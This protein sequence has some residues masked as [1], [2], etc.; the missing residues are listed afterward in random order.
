VINVSY[1]PNLNLIERV[2]KFVKQ[3]VLYSRYYIDFD[4]FKGSIEN[5][6]EE[7]NSKNKYKIASLMTLKF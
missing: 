1:S 4:S 7:I 3:E 2:W 6:L 5:C